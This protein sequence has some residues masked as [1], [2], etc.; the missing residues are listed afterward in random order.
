M[1]SSRFRR[2]VILLLVSLTVCLVGIGSYV[3]YFSSVLDEAKRESKLAE[4]NRDWDK[5]LLWAR[6][7]TE[8]NPVNTDA[9]LQRATAAKQL[10]KWDE[11][12]S[13]LE[14]I[15]AD[16]ENFFEAN[17]LAADTL[18][19][20]LY[21]VEDAERILTKLHEL[22]PNRPY[23]VQRLTFLYSMTQQRTKLSK[24]LLEAIEHQVEP[25]EAYFYLFTLH[26]LL[27]TN[28]LLKTTM[29]KQTTPEFEP[30]VVSNAIY[31]ARANPTEASNLF[32][33]DQAVPGDVSQLKKL[34]ENRYPHNEE[35]ICYLIELGIDNGNAEEV[36]K[37]TNQFRSE[38]HQT[39]RYCRY[40]G[41]LADNEGDLSKSMDFYQ[42]ALKIDPLDWSTHLEIGNVY[43]AAGQ[44]SQAEKELEIAIRGKELARNM[45]KLPS[46][47]EASEEQMFALLTY[48]QDCGAKDMANAYRKRLKVLGMNPPKATVTA[49]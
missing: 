42:S 24:L 10:S 9:W 16:H 48:I 46:N 38:H 35:L 23:V 45:M 40:Q 34:L 2:L 33:D 25:R 14:Q 43:R 27:F 4:Q 31:L 41:W 37:L 18:I 32:G 19:S 22:F 28:G 12:V 47:Y 8:L 1:K 26:D 11:L 17:A 6:K 44:L 30:L 21:N 36:K 29:W 39:S 20:E 15:P 7:W 49:K 5:A 3:A 13:C